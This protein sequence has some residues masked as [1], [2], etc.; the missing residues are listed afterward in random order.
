LRIPSFSYPGGKHYQRRWIVS[1]F[2]RS[3]PG[4]YVEPFAGRANVF[5]F[6]QSV[7]EATGGYWLNDAFTAGFLTALADMGDDEIREAVGGEYPAVETYKAM[8]RDRESVRA[9]LLEPLIT[10]SGGGW[11]QGY[12]SGPKAPTIDG[13]LD[14]LIAASRILR[15]RRGW[16]TATD[17]RDVLRHCRRGDFVYVDP[18]YKGCDVRA[19]KSRTVD[20]TGLA[21]TLSGS[22]FSWVL[23]EYDDPIY[24]EILGDPTASATTTLKVSGNLVCKEERTECLWVKVSD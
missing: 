10:F 7:C 20:H 18:P 16:I 11:G 19:Y 1:R 13:Y 2:P 17:Y 14:R 24:R 23:S 6:A 4:R 3:I 8:S 22:E 15:A 5:W 12:R 21:E 9:N